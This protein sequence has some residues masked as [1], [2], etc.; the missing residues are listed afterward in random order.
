M[1]D[2][3]RAWDA[4]VE[5]AS[6]WGVGKQEESACHLCTPWRCVRVRVRR[7]R[8]RAAGPREKAGRMGE[9]MA[10]FMPVR[11]QGDIQNVISCVQERR[12][13]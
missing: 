3:A 5:T 4:R 6:C 2:R 10:E 1:F 7:R 8:R 11:R 9:T 13:L 12:N